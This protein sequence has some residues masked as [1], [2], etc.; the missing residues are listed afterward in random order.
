M[1][2]PKTIL[3]GDVGATK[4]YLGFFHAEGG[5]AVP[6]VERAFQNAPYPRLAAL[7]EDFFRTEGRPELSS[8]CFGVA[9]TPVGDRWAMTNLPWVIQAQTLRPVLRT[10]RIF[11]LND[12]EALGYGIPALAP[13]HWVALN[14][15]HPAPEANAAVIAAGTGL[16]E[17]ILFWDGQRHRPMATEGG[18]ADFA[19]RTAVEIEFLRYALQRLEHVSYER[20]VS[21]PGL[22]LMYRFLVE[23][24]YGEEPA[25]LAAQLK[26]GD[27][28]AAILEAA[29]AG[30]SELAAKAV[31]MFVHAYG[32]E[33]GNLALKALARAGVYIG[34]GIAPRIADNLREGAFMQAFKDKGRLSPL[35]ADIPVWVVME[36]KASFYGAAAY[37]AQQEG[38]I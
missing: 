34:G 19:P 8:A 28:S 4:T 3:A 6:H 9:A 18:H 33:A 2:A 30:N 24:G 26:G 7:L 10:E 5:R 16:G 13:E 32:A 29:L 27:P 21:G 11:L 25:W 23:A 14:T 15:G 1:P 35:V 20:V 17:C 36:P 31:D 37:A 12:L 22:H 38:R